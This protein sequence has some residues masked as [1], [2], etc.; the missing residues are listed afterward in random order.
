M[1]CQ[2]GKHDLETVNMKS[3]VP[4]AQPISVDLQN[5]IKSAFEQKGEQYKPRTHHFE[6]DGSP[7]YTNRL[8][9]ETSPYLLQHAHNP[10]DWFPW[11]EEAFR[12]A[13]KLN[14]PVLLS[15]GYSTCHWCHVMERES[16]EDV[17]IATF[18]NKHFIAIKVDREERPDVDSIY[19]TTVQLMRGSGGWPMTVVMTSDRKPFFGGTYFPARDGDRGNAMGFLTILRRLEE[20]FRN[21][22]KQVIQAANAIT[23]RLRQA[24]LPRPPT[25]VPDAQALVAI[26]Q[27]LFE[28]FDHTYGGFGRAPKFPRPS[29]YE[30]LLHYW[31]RTQDADALKMVEVSLSGMIK[32]GIFD[33]LAGGFHRYSTDREWL[34][35][36]FEKM[37]YD[38]AQLSFL[39]IQLC[40]ITKDNAFQRSAKETLNYVLREMTDTKGGFFSATDADSEGKEG[41]FFLWTPKEV[42]AILDTREAQIFMEAYDVTVSGNF[43]GKSILRRK[44][45]WKSLIEKFELT[46]TELSNILANAKSKL[47]EARE[48]REHPILDD[49]I[50]VEWNAQMI[51]AFAFAGLVFQ[52]PKYTQAAISAGEFIWENMQEGGK[53]SRTYR[54]GK[55]KHD[56]VLEDYAFLIE[57]FLQLFE[58][59]QDIRW[60]QRSLTLEATLNTFFYDQENGGYFTT[61][62]SS[63]SLLVREKPSYDGA[64]PSGNSVIIRVLLKLSE[65]TQDTKY[66]QRAE[67]SMLAMSGALENGSIGSPKLAVA[68]EWMLDRPKQVIIITPTIGKE[69]ALLKVLRDTFVPNKILIVTEDSEVEKLAVSLPLVENKTAKDGQ[70]TA[71]VCI[72]QVCLKPTSDPET[73]R[74]QL[75]AAEKLADQIP[76]LNE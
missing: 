18:I 65:Y 34:A 59:T 31:R 56:A 9:F 51:R 72:G 68:L 46:S 48:R 33:H 7:K 8:I 5:K 21:D 27:I 74:E 53:L 44:S 54:A 12:L 37:L 71:Y 6:N 14:R 1:S 39:L 38:N 66:Q 32:G 42:E 11:G 69:A 36:H 76:P 58:T 45:K 16:F 70:A 25:G 75:E 49:K 60:L 63:E 26:A 3:M 67:K 73:L 62:S 43:E 52:N 20:A 41:T 57:A 50:I 22:P 19:M 24:S 40:Q 30:F 10:V 61:S 13:A 47:Y 28:E 17:E 23:S 4:G 64:Q 29:V 15:V 2:H 35:P 55:A